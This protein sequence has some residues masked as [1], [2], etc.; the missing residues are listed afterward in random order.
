MIFP[1]N[2]VD[3]GRIIWKN[4]PR[5]CWI[6]GW[7]WGVKFHL[8][9]KW[10]STDCY[11][12]LCSL[13]QPLII[14]IMAI[15]TNVYQ[16]FM[17]IFVYIWLR[18]NIVDIINMLKWYVEHCCTFQ[19]FNILILY[20]IDMTINNNNNIGKKTQEQKKNK[21]KRMRKKRRNKQIKLRTKIFYSLI[22]VVCLW[23]ICQFHR[24]GV[25]YKTIIFLLFFLSLSLSKLLGNFRTL[26]EF[27]SCVIC[28]F[29]V[30]MLLANMCASTNQCAV[31][32]IYLYF[33]MYEYFHSQL[34]YAFHEYTFISFEFVR[35][36]WKYHWF[37]N[38]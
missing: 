10:D 23:W 8:Y 36:W 19:S 2:D 25:K 30:Q 18:I 7:G 21:D 34:I 12:V 37:Q 31:H 11:H 20:I 29:A 27:F 14:T 32:L 13:F 16:T 6:I 5:R 35:I 15:V 1:Q 17:N 4:K 22:C 38:G 28:F 9:L 24:N 3:F 33:F 26:R